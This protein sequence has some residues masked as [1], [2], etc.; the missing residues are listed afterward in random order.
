MSYY[1]YKDHVKADL[2]S[3]IVT[4]YTVTAASVHDS[5]EFVNLLE[6]DDKVVYADSGYIG[7][8]DEFSQEILKNVDFQICEKGYKNRPLTEEQKKRNKEKSHFRSRIE[9]IFGFMTGSMRGL[10]LRCI[11]KARAEFNIAI[12]NLVYNMCRYGIIMH[13]KAV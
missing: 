4:D 6:K 3:K 1:G 8:E 12:T 13:Q 10:T 7:K 5:T 9:H 11:G 2:K